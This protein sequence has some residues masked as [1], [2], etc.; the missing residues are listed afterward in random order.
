MTAATIDRV[1]QVIFLLAAGGGSVLDV[2]KLFTP[3]T[4]VFGHFVQ[5]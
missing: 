4:F 3:Q 5:T 2:T 1:Q